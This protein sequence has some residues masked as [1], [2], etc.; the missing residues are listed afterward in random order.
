MR[1]RVFFISILSTIIFFLIISLYFEFNKIISTESKIWEK[2]IQADCAVVVTGGPGRIREGIDLLAIGAVKKVIIS[3]VNPNSVYKEI[4]PMWVHYS[5][6]N[7]SDV[8]L[9]KR[10]ETTFGNAVQS[11]PL[12]ELLNCQDIA[13]I[14]S[15]LHMYR[16]VKTFKKVFPSHIEIKAH[17]L[18]G[19]Q[20][21]VT[22]FEL[23]QETFKSLFYSLWAYN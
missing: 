7:E 9:E 14:T 15:W 23:F 17:P 2:S 3:G 8:I 4:F 19:S 18:Q 13:L 16:T 5:E 10:S 11:L 12:V 21:Q 20:T 1:R 6:V 22:L